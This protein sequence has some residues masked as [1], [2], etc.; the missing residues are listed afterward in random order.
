[1]KLRAVWGPLQ[2][3]PWWPGIYRDLLPL[4]MDAE[5]VIMT[6]AWYTLWNPCRGSQIAW[7]YWK[8]MAMLKWTASDE[9]LP[10]SQRLKFCLASHIFQTFQMIRFY[11]R[12]S[13]WIEQRTRS[14][15]RDLLDLQMTLD[16]QNTMQLWG[17]CFE[18]TKDSGES[19][20]KECLSS[21][22]LWRYPPPWTPREGVLLSETLLRERT[23]PSFLLK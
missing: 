11:Q 3:F 21:V 7:G 14:T 10:E 2:I 4:N 15:L 8:R 1:M 19:S 18:H 12:A 22:L 16:P 23:L 9:I 17:F 13:S 6:S 20:G 5:R